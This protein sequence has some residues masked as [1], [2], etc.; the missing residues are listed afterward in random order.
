LW[1]GCTDPA[2]SVFEAMA[3]DPDRGT[4]GR[5]LTAWQMVFSKMPAMVRDAVKQASAFYDEHVDMR[6]V[7][8]D[9]ADERGEINRRKLG[10]WIRRHSG[11]IVDGRRFVRASG[12]RSAEAWQVELVESVSSV[13]VPPGVETFSGLW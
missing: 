1:L 5:L 12:N 4:L 10:W 13:S 7:F 6:E 9:I 8:H 11:W 2:V 3:E